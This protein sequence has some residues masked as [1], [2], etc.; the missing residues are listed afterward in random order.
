ME[1]FLQV[2]S[3]WGASLTGN[4]MSKDTVMEKHMVYLEHAMTHLT[5]CQEI[6][7]QKPIK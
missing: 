6:G 2:G 7:K 4:S 3:W 1:A 5:G